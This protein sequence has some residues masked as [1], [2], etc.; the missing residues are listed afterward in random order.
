MRYAHRFAMGSKNK[1]Y[2][3]VLL[4]FFVILIAGC[5]RKAEE[6]QVEPQ[7][8]QAAD[9]GIL[10]VVSAPSQAHVYINSELK[11][12]T[13]LTLYNMPVGAY[14]VAIKKEGYVDFEKTVAVKVGRTEEVS[15]ALAPLTTPK[16]VEEKK[17]AQEI[18]PEDMPALPAKLNTINI[19]KSFIIYFDFDKEL[20]TNIATPTPDI[21]SSRYD[22][23]VY[24]TAI[25]PANILLVNK[26]I[27]DVKKEDC[28]KSKDVVANVYSGQT[29]CVR[30]R[31]GIIA[32]VGGSWTTTPSELEW[33]V[34]S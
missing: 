33:V 21:F 2:M 17:T 31:E 13:P 34:F 3:L 4:A 26:Q 16:A 5:A 11:G 22:T 29:L 10:A 14:S 30:T 15:A 12:E 27:K 24:F 32:A 6:F 28:T 23:Y 1:R 20:F 19:S 9:T 25:S 8:E 18:T 7:Q